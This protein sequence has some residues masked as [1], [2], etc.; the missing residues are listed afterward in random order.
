VLVDGDKTGKKTLD[1]RQQNQFHF[2][3]PRRVGML[4]RS[5]SGIDGGKRFISHALLPKSI[6]PD[7]HPAG[8][9]IRRR[10]IMTTGNGSPRTAD[11]R[12]NQPLAA[13]GL[14]IKCRLR[15][16]RGR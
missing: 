11:S 6:G 9:D 15:P 16:R 10:V 1:N 2:K 7:V 5:A 4:A 8:H 12:E 3:V 13:S 14:L